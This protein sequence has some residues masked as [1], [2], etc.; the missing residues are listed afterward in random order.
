LLVVEEVAS[1]RGWPV[2][3][4]RGVTGDGRREGCK[5][6]AP[7]GRATGSVANAAKEETARS[8]QPW[9][10][11][12]ATA[13]EAM[14]VCWSPVVLARGRARQRKGVETGEGKEAGDGW[15][16]LLGEAMG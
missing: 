10:E 8:A 15:V 14:A 3:L 4:A 9:V 5:N 16:F 11:T 2:A 1:D 13:A 6:R 7:M 12:T